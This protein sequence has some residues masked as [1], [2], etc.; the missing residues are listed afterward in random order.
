MPIEGKYTTI[1]SDYEYTRYGT[2]SLLTG[3]DLL[4]GIIY[5][6]VYGRHQGAEFVDFLK[7]I[8]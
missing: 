8:N 2:L 7:I 5:Y 4:T 6:R 1:S 3:I